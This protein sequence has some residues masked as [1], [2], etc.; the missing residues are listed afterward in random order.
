MRID[1]KLPDLFFYPRDTLIYFFLSLFKNCLR[2][3]ALLL[4]ELLR[5]LTS[6][7]QVRT[8]KHL[9]QSSQIQL[10]MVHLI[11]FRFPKLVNRR[12]AL[13]IVAFRCWVDSM[14]L[15]D[16]LNLFIAPF[17]YDIQ[18]GLHNRFLWIL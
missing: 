10:V 17:K 12:R 8:R 1:L 16:C 7:V 3:R 6:L 4:I 14:S 18:I 5:I 13:G 11:L 2:V 15:H 9:L